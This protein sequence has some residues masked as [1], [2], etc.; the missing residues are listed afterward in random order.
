[1]ISMHTRSTPT[2]S[3]QVDCHFIKSRVVAFWVWILGT[4]SN[5]DIFIVVSKLDQGAHFRA[6]SL[7]Q[8]PMPFTHGSNDETDI[9]LVKKEYPCSGE[10]KPLLSKDMASSSSA[11]QDAS[12]RQVNVVP[13]P[14][15][16]VHRL[17]IH[18]VC[19]KITPVYCRVHWKCP[20]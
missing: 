1:M 11:S 16:S 7:H 2:R 5:I 14:H 6:L 10:L 9:Y 18:T 15:L 3:H 8:P 17:W 20:P 13:P 12:I 4:I 19:S